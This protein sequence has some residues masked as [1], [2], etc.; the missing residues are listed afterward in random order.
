MCGPR[1]EEDSEET[2]TESEMTEGTEE[3]IT[4]LVEFFAKR[5]RRGMP[6][7]PTEHIFS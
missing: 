3:T 2:G 5:T 1:N 6:R 7:K 4:D